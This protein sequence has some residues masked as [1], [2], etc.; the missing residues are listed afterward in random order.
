[1]VNLDLEDDLRRWFSDGFA[2]QQIF[3]QSRK[4][5]KKQ[6]SA[7]LIISLKAQPWQ[8]AKFYTTLECLRF[9]PAVFW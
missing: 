3:Q 5:N 9:E 4:T 2:S 1:M 6:T 7:L 8:Y